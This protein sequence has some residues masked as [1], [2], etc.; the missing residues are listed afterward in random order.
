VDYSAINKVENEEGVNQ[1]DLMN[2]TVL[3]VAKLQVISSIIKKE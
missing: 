1:S 3:I 2:S